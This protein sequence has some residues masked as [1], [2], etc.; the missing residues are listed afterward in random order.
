M[1][2]ARVMPPMMRR[3][4]HQ[5]PSGPSVHWAAPEYCQGDISVI[6][7]F[8]VQLLQR[9]QDRVQRFAQPLLG[10]DLRIGAHISRS[11]TPAVIAHRHVGSAIAFQ[12]RN[13]STRP[14]WEN[15]ASM[16][17]SLMKLDSP[18]LNVLVCSSEEP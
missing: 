5:S 9:E 6:A 3:A 8:V 7:P 12:K 4:Q 15:L 13:T 1:V 2:N 16:R 17:T 14:G 11:V 10:D 18:A